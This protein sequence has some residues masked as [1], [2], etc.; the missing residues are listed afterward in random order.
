[1]DLF[2]HCSQ[3]D[4]AILGSFL[5]L[6][7][8]HVDWCHLMLCIWDRCLKGGCGLS[9]VHIVRT[10][11][12]SYKSGYFLWLQWSG[13]AILGLIFDVGF[14]HVHWCLL[15]FILDRCFSGISGPKF[16]SI[17]LVTELSIMDIF[18]NCSHAEKSNFGF[19]FDVDFFAFGIMPFD[20]GHPRQVFEKCLRS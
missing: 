4:E 3:A 6:G 5:M 10:C 13:K 18:H 8:L 7:F 19:I 15:V 9:F 12:L 11:N 16:L 2:H 14:L 1:M 17:V 20:V